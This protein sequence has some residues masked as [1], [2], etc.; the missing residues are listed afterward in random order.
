ML[1]C[2]W[3]SVVLVISP[4]I[5]CACTPSPR[6]AIT[7]GETISYELIVAKELDILDAASE[8][9]RLCFPD[10][11]VASLGGKE[12]G[13]TFSKEHFPERLNKFL[14]T[15]AYGATPDGN[16][17]VGY[18]YFIYSNDQLLSP[19]SSDVQPLIAEFKKTLAD[20][21]ITLIWVQSIKSR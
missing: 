6:I 2:H 4:M 5:L 8:A 7:E 11:V 17:I 13:F 10:A 15:K 20:K 18:R 12:K 14:I 21:G 19:E 3:M 16:D 9:I 1:K